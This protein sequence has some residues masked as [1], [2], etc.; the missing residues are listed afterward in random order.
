MGWFGK[1][2]DDKHNEGIIFIAFI[3]DSILVCKFIMCLLFHII[4][5]SILIRITLMIFKASVYILSLI[6]RFMV[7]TWGPSGADRTQVGPMLAPWTLLSGLESQ[8]K[9][10]WHFVVVNDYLAKLWLRYLIQY[11][12]IIWFHGQLFPLTSVWCLTWPVSKPTDNPI[13]TLSV[14][15]CHHHLLSVRFTFLIACQY[16]A[17]H[18]LLTSQRRVIRF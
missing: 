2:Y 8:S 3:I 11:A 17:G 1:M 5:S 9:S 7:P 16:L 10:S 18:L 4:K 6:A 14:L 13:N 15:F 12:T